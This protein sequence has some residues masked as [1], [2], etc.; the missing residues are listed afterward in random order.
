M[1]RNE[2]K[3]TTWSKT[4]PVLSSSPCVLPT[5]RKMSSSCFQGQSRRYVLT[6]GASLYCRQAPM[7][8]M[9]VDLVGWEKL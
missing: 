5:S 1:K 6:L 9:A 3:E 4:M 8:E 2:R 7:Q